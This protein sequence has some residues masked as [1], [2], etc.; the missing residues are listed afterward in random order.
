[1]EER[2]DFWRTDTIRVGDVEVCVLLDMYT[3]IIQPDTEH[4]VFYDSKEKSRYAAYGAE[5]IFEF[6]GDLSEEEHEMWYDDAKQAVSVATELGW[7]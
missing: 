2:E 4:M 6:M 7:L 3:G 5:A 1:M